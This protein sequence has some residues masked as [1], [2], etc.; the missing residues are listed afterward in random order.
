MFLFNVTSVSFRKHFMGILKDISFPNAG[1]N[2]PADSASCTRKLEYSYHAEVLKFCSMFTVKTSVRFCLCAR[3]ECIHGEVKYISTLYQLE[4]I[5]QLYARKRPSPYALN[6]RY[7]EPQKQSGPFE[8]YKYLTL[9]LLLPGIE[10]LFI[11]YSA[12]YSVTM[13]TDITQSRS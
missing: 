7:V 11:G 9:L 10:Q 2:F 1:I 8:I 5:R 12:R 4:A 13:S 3:H 6:R